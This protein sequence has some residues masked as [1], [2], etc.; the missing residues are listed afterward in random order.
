[1]LLNLPD[2]Q[3]FEGKT[4]QLSTNLSVKDRPFYLD[5][6]PTPARCNSLRA[7]YA[8]VRYLWFL[9][10]FVASCIVLLKGALAPVYL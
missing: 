10:A 9:A 7:I 8:Y 6:F 5:I 2:L 1:M 3:D 4:P